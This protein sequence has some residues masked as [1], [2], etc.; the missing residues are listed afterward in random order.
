M[1]NLGAVGRVRGRLW[2]GGRAGCR[3]ARGSGF[4]KAAAV[5]Q[6]LAA[7]RVARGSSV[8]SVP[9]LPRGRPSRATP[10]DQAADKSPLASERTGSHCLQKF[11]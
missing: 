2:G 5:S 10:S 8:H 4:T 7:F 3:L 1:N 11:H 6:T 9:S